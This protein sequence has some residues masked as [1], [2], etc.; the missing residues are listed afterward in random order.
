MAKVFTGGAAT[1]KDLVVMTGFSTL[2]ATWKA[3][4]TVTGMASPN[5]ETVLRQIEQLEDDVRN[6]ESRLA[7]LDLLEA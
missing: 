2:L 4:A 6:I 7:E 5:K 3:D 1:A